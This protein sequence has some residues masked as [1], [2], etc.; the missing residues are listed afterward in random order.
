MSRKLKNKKLAI[1][2]Y[3]W[4]MI[5]CFFMFKAP[6]FSFALQIKADCEKYQPDILTHHCKPP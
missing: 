1:H 5:K 6:H 2:V 4:K 3:N